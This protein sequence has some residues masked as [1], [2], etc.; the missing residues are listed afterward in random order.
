MPHLRLIAFLHLF[1]LVPSLANAADN[2]YLEIPLCGVFGEPAYRISEQNVL[3]LTD[4]TSPK[5]IERTLEFASKNG[6]KHIVF[7]IDSPG[8]LLSTAEAIVD[9]MTK[10]DDVLEYHAL[11]K[12]G[13]SASIWIIFACDTIYVTSDTVIGA[14]VPYTGK[15]GAVQVDEKFNSAIAAKL[16]TIAESKGHST[17]LLRAM[18][19]QGAAVYASTDIDGTTSISNV[20]PTDSKG[21]S[22]N[23]VDTAETVLTLTGQEAV[24]LGLAKFAPNNASDLGN[25]PSFNGWVLANRYVAISTLFDFYFHN[26]SAYKMRQHDFGD[27]TIY[28]NSPDDR[29]RSNF[30]KKLS[31]VAEV[32]R[33]IEQSDPE[34]TTYEYY[35]NG[36]L[37]PQSA[38]KRWELKTKS[39]DL[40]KRLHREST[41]GTKIGI[42]QPWR[43]NLRI[44][45]PTK[46]GDPPAAVQLIWQKKKNP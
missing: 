11:V 22:I 2:Q 43:R 7:R 35:A 37:T 21:I 9:I 46:P 3:E 18:I 39:I 44:P 5:I 15:L 29:R 33:M 13:L 23:A 26:P 25:S 16:A 4:N 42:Y 38:E 14:A 31:K 36:E 40:W 20:L 17:V 32:I 8:G 12:K 10:Y 34:L 19:L 6:I 24:E 45:I 1:L 41:K 27:I 28:G 30:D